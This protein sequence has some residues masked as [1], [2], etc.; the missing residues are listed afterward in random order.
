MVATPIYHPRYL[1]FCAPAVALLVAA[2]IARLPRRGA[3]AAVVVAVVVLSLVVAVSQRGPFAKSGYDWA[4]AAGVVADHRQPGD[5][6]YYG[7]RTVP[8]GDVVR[9]SQRLV[10]SGY[11]EAFEGLTDVTLLEPAGPAA[12]LM[13]TSVPLAERADALR[14]VDRLWVLRW[15]DYPRPAS[16]TRMPRLPTPGSSPSRSRTR[17]SRA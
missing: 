13:G 2:G 8:E 9:K 15:D 14:D 10:A 12:W 4:Y 17:A 3:R 1:A 6:V 5:A 7:P 11:P 16:P